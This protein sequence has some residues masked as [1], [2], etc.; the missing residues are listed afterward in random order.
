MFKRK[1]PVLAISLASMA[2]MAAPYVPPPFEKVPDPALSALRITKGK[3]ISTGIVFVNGKLVPGP[4]VVSRYGTVIRV[5]REQV[6]GQVVPWVQFTTT[7]GARPPARPQAAAPVPPPAPAP[8]KPAAS[9]VDD[10]F[11]DDPAPAAAAAAPRP[12]A[13]AAA[14]APAAPVPAGEYVDSPRSKNLLKRI[15]D[16]RTEVD[17]TLRGNGVYFF[18]ARYSPIR[19]ESRLAKELMAV[20]PDALRDAND[21]RNLYDILRRK[22]ITYIPAAVCVDLMRDRALYI[23]VRD[24]LREIKEEQSFHNMLNNAGGRL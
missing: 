19:V 10:L 22:G 9:S 6:T 18:G 17:R 7:A 8:A 14:P 4:Y 1:I 11:D 24:R 2:L 23:K 5:N 3:V 21:A 12:A 16:Y 20:L 15:N 13:P